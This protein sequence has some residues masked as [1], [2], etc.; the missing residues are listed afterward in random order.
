[1]P[2]ITSSG[3][4]A[5]TDLAGRLLADLSAGRTARQSIG[6]RAVAFEWASGLPMIL[7]RQVNSAVVDG[8]SY[9]AVRVAPSGT[10]AGPVAPGAAKP[11]AVTITTDTEALTKYAGIATFQTE[12]ALDADGLVPALASVIGN[13]CLMAYDASCGAV[14][15]ADAGLTASGADWPSAILAGIAAVAGAGGA[16]GVLSIGAA[17]YAEVVK[18]PGA[19][20]AMNPVDGVPAMYGLR[21]VLGAGIA[22]GTAFVID[23]NAVLATEN[24]LSPLAIV[25]PYAAMATNEIS[26]AV[27]MFAG[28]TVTSPGG[29]CE[30]TKTVAGARGGGSGGTAKAR[31]AYALGA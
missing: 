26:L 29:V 14:L 18:S 6:S 23:P 27:E 24:A 10:P 17:D 2:V 15:T 12:Q 25:N 22:A 16:P 3:P 4:P 31:S 5:V 11:Q 13:S 20:Y 7:A 8:L 28:F 21:I 30:V 19:G 9:R 1:M